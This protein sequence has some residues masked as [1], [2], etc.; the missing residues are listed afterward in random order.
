MTVAIPTRPG[1]ALNPKSR[2]RLLSAMKFMS[3][4]KTLHSDSTARGED[5]GLTARG[6][7]LGL[8]PSQH[9]PVSLAPEHPMLSTVHRQEMQAKHHTHLVKI[10]MF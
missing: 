8:V 2:L 3:F 4:S 5:L 1:L 6:E 9:S 7:D 10:N